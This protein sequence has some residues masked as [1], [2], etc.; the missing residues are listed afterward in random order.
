M[1]RAAPW[2]TTPTT[3]VKD[4]KRRTVPTAVAGCT[5]NSKM[6]I[7]VMSDPPPIPVIPTRTPTKNPDSTYKGSTAIKNCISPSHDSI[8]PVAIPALPGD[9]N[10]RVSEV[11]IRRKALVILVNLSQM[12]I[13]LGDRGVRL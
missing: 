2:T 13:Y 12:T 10:C 5:P 4:A 1:F 8:R 3:L 9:D 7:G 11:E 6:S